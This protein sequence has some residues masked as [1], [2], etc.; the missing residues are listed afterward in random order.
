MN[1]SSLQLASY[2]V[3]PAGDS[4]RAYP[5]SA[6]AFRTGFDLDRHRVL[7]C[8]AFRRLEYKT[9]VFVTHEGDHFRT[10]LTHSLEVAHLAVE[11]ARA[12]RVNV[13]LAETV[14]LAHDLGHTPFGHAGESALNERMSEHGGFEHNRQS[15]RVV[16][17]LEH[18]YP[19][20]RGLNLMA[21]TL[22]CLAAHATRYD[23]PDD[24][25]RQLPVEGQITNL[26]DRLAYAGHD[27]EDALGA[28]LIEEGDLCDLTIWSD[29]AGPIRRAYPDRSIFAVRRPIIDALIREV[30]TAVVD[31]TRRRL[32]AVA[33]VGPDDVRGAS[34]PVVLLPEPI[35]GRFSEL[36]EFLLERVY[37]HPRVG[38]MDG[39][40]KKL[41][42]GAFDAFLADPTLLPPRFARRIEEQGAHR[43]VCDYVAGM[44]DRFLE[45]EHRRLCG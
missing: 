17:Y 12:L 32:E 26:A 33:P 19:A 22:E 36:E 20:F 21:E 10:R 2:A 29:A 13:L 27:L 41:V 44:T 43:V 7:H 45:S 11:L 23:H 6:D 24:S 37:R 16:T 34:G 30:M 1:P 3:D 18:P 39:R 42:C 35:A 28:G 9:Q 5:E 25:G 4:G 38:A 14:A 40:G 31:E 8:T 15:L